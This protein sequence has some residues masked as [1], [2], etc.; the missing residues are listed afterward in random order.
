MTRFLTQF[1]AL[2]L[3]F[4]LLPLTRLQAATVPQSGNC[5][6]TI[7]AIESKLS[8]DLKPVLSA[9][10]FPNLPW[11]KPG[12]TNWVKVLIVA[13]SPDP[14]LTD[15]RAAVLQA[16]GS[17]HFKFLSVTA[18][19][20]VLP[21]NQVAAIAQRCDVVSMSPNLQTRRSGGFLEDIT[22]TTAVRPIL[23][24]V[25]SSL[26]YTSSTTSESIAEPLDGTGIGVAILDSGIMKNHQ[27]MLDAAG[28]SRV[29][30]SVDILRSRV[31]KDLQFLNLAI[32][33]P[34]TDRAAS[35]GMAL[36]R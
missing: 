11:T 25:M 5:P 26:A 2:L 4:G 6:L 33:R 20:A 12:T 23:S 27:M 32:C 16:G 10:P 3:G 21:V 19:L 14:E 35:A 7:F 15:L 29:K 17:V 9:S 24:A 31:S 34:S 28:K 30:Y 18:I 1:L 13:A 36:K 22:G 8:P